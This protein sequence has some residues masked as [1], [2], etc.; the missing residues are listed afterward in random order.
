MQA[1]ILAA[2]MGRRLAEHTKN[3]TKCMVEVN[4][5]SLIDR[6]LTQLSALQLCRVVIVIGYKGK[7]LTEHIGHRY[8]DRLKIEYVTNPIYDTTNNIYSLALAKEQLIEDD[9]LLLESD[10]IIDDCILDL[11]INNP[12]P[13]L[14]LVAKYESWMDGTMVRMDKERNIVNFV[15]KAAFRYKDTDSYY[16]TLNIYKF[17]KA[18]SR[19]KYV[20]FLEAYTK[21]VGNN[22]YYENVLRIISFLDSHDMKALPLTN[23]KWYE[24]DDKQDLDIA[25]ALFADEKD[26]IRKYFLLLGDCRV[27]RTSG[28]PPEVAG[29]KCQERHPVR[30]E[31]LCVP[32]HGGA[33]YPSGGCK[34]LVPLFADCP[35][36]RP[37]LQCQV[38]SLANLPLPDC[39]G[40]R[41]FPAAGGK[42]QAHLYSTGHHG[43]SGRRH[44]HPLPFPDNPFPQVV[45]H[46]AAAGTGQHPAG[47]CQC[48]SQRPEPP[49]FPGR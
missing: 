39:G 18:F 44:V 49:D 24:I 5:V 20:P 11:L 29:G 32:D 6:M 41:L 40:G 26:I 4:G 33:E 47:Q 8:D 45:P 14:A 28:R 17:S 31:G 42:P 2:G 38:A 30:G 22:E 34:P 23:E 19:N 12:E 16:K 7:E 10:L 25:E 43:C 15:P 9:T 36:R 48:E 46:P 1:I 35:G 3:N 13:N 37:V 21:S 27:K